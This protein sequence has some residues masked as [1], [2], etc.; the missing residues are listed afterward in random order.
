MMARPV[1]AALAGAVEKAT[2]HTFSDP[3]LMQLALTHSS[4]RARHQTDNERLEFLGDRV[5]GVV[6]A[7]LLFH[8]FP[9]ADQGELAV[10]HSALVSGETCAEIADETG[11]TPLIH[12]DAG[13][14]G[15]KGRKA[16]NIRADAVEAMIAAIYLDGGLEAARGFVRAHWEP[17]SRVAAGT[18]RDPKTTLQEWAHQICGEP[19]TY[20]ITA[21]EGPDH[22]P[23]FT[24][25]VQV[26]DLAPEN[27]SG[28]SKRAAEQ[29]A[30]T[31]LL[32]REGVWTGEG[33]AR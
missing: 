4:V 20:E 26:G 3:E 27:G 2:G 23:L 33:Q 7:D 18:L 9:D 25:S 30:A 10:R 16:K 22:D 21:R 11:L 29:A 14:R 19:P 1:G 8:A 12:A 31:A 32:M 28:R 5:L 17:R 13:V 15:Q 24:I 6:V